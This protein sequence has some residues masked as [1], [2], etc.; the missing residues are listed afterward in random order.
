MH[1]QSWYRRTCLTWSW[2]IPRA[3]VISART[4]T[5]ASR[6]CSSST[7]SLQSS[8]P[9]STIIPWGKKWGETGKC[10]IQLLITSTFNISGISRTEQST[11][12]VKTKRSTLSGDL[13][14]IKT[15]QTAFLLTSCFFEDFQIWLYNPSR[16]RRWWKVICVRHFFSFCPSRQEWR[17]VWQVLKECYARMHA[18]AALFLLMAKEKRRLGDAWASFQALWWPREIASCGRK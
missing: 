12:W 9:R 5:S 10:S 8:H 4:G 7:S 13:R 11:S 18:S 1:M 2:T 6:S 3:R 15:T 14:Q 16:L 17:A